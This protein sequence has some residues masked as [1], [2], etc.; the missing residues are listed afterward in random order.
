MRFRSAIVAIAAVGLL[1]A[2]CSSD[3]DSS[4]TSEAPGSAPVASDAPST[5]PSTTV[6]STDVPTTDVAT[7]IPATTEPVGNP[8][9]V[10][11][12]P[13]LADDVALPIVFVHGFAGSAQQYESQKMR[14][15]ANGYPVDRIVVFEHDGA[16]MDI[17]GYAAGLTAVVDATLAN[18]SVDQVSPAA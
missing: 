5:D 4:G 1:A 7:T 6:E 13:P 12:L 15:V 11:P 17:A 14:L 9:G 2:G 8:D 3:D 10:D 16:G 18:F